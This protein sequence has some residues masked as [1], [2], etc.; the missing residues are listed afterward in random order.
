MNYPELIDS[1]K[2]AIEN[3]RCLG[4]IALEDPLFRGNPYCEYGRI[5]TAKESIKKI[6]KILG[7]QETVWK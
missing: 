2:K 4:C 7:I 5:P 1:C 3:G 6:H